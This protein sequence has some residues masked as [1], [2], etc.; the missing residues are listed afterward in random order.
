VYL[1]Q[2]GETKLESEDPERPLADK[3]RSEV[4]SVARHIANSGVT[5]NRIFHSGRLGAKQRAEIFAQHAT[6]DQGVVQRS[7]LRS[8]GDPAEARQMVEQ[9]EESVMLKAIFLT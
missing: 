2:H 3:G 1:V 9:A 5:I 8:M 6:P 7:G 4:E